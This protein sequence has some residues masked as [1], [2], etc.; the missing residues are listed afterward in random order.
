VAEIDF[1]AE[2]DPATLTMG[3]NKAASSRARN[4][5]YTVKKNLF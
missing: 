5:K 2:A 3:E 1:K 4:I